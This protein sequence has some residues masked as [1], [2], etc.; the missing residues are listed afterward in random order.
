MRTR[1]N[2]S[3]YAKQNAHRREVVDGLYNLAIKPRDIT[4][5]EKV[6]RFLDGKKELSIDV[7][8][9]AE[10]GFQTRD[11]NYFIQKYEEIVKVTNV[12]LIEA[13]NELNDYMENFGYLFQG[14]G[15]GEKKKHE[16]WPHDLEKNVTVLSNRVIRS[17]AVIDVIQDEL[18]NREK[19]AEKAAELEREHKEKERKKVLAKIQEWRRARK[20][21]RP[22]ARN[23]T[24]LKSFGELLSH[25]RKSGQFQTE[26]RISKS[27]AEKHLGGP[28][29]LAEAFK[30]AKENKTEVVSTLNDGRQICWKGNRYTLKA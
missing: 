4:E 18:N 8:S 21:K 17:E 3:V 2:K 1:T 23:E 7:N 22:V 25:N 15:D 20:A 30:T 10:F 26:I 27:D 11:L 14:M 16:A 24:K 6:R 12:N 13:K 9:P 29:Q 28:D 19:A 5:P